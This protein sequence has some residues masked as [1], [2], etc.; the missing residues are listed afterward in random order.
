MRDYQHRFW[1]H[2]NK[3]KF[4]VKLKMLCLNIKIFENSAELLSNYLKKQ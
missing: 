3:S 4:E 1:D 2:Q